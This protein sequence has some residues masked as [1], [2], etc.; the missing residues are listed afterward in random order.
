LN[1]TVLLR[2]VLHALHVAGGT[3]KGDVDTARGGGTSSDTGREGA[4]SDIGHGQ[5]T[6]GTVD[7]ALEDEGVATGWVDICVVVVAWASGGS[8]GRVDSA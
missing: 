3:G 2:A 1:A 5:V 7:T 6:A 8:D 4:W